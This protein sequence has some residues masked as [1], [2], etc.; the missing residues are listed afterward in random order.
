MTTF[1]NIL[2]NLDCVLVTNSS[3]LKNGPVRQLKYKPIRQLLF[4]NHKHKVFGLVATRQT[5]AYISRFK[6]ACLGNPVNDDSYKSFKRFAKCTLPLD[7]EIYAAESPDKLYV[8]NEYKLVAQTGYRYLGRLA[9]GEGIRE[10]SGKSRVI[11]KVSAKDTDLVRYVAGFS[12][13][14][15]S[16]VQAR[17]LQCLKS[18]TSSSKGRALLMSVNPKWP[19]LRSKFMD[20]KEFDVSIEKEI[21]GFPSNIGC[22][23]RKLNEVALATC[24]K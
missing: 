24:G 10:Q 8:F 12:D 13:Y 6:E 1:E 17:V 20:S 3:S 5:L 9:R 2:K 22:I 19:E 18:G 21:E 4:V 23:V 7:W 16:K 15:P 11:F 14:E